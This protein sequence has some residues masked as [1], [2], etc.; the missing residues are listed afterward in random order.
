MSE[1]PP[2]KRA[3]AISRGGAGAARIAFPLA[4]EVAADISA[5][6]VDAFVSDPTQLTNG[7][8]ELARAVGSDAIVCADQLGMS[9]LDPAVLLAAPRMAA[10]LEACRRLRAAAGDGVALVAIFEGPAALAMR[11]GDSSALEA[12]GTAISA[13]ARAF[14]EAGTDIFLIEEPAPPADEA[15]WR[16]AVTTL[17]RV[18]KFHR[19]VA[20]SIDAPLASPLPAP[21]RLPLSSPP[22]AASGVVTTDVRVTRLD[23]TAMTAWMH[24][25]RSTP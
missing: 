8:T 6:P 16:S 4:F 9:S 7:L 2:R 11:T 13:I 15:A 3:Q 20:M 22:P 23:L 18:A 21:T 1:L 10:S 5:R 14:A 25:V 24:A 19:G 17:S 12:A